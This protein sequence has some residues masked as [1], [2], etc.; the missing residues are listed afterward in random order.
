LA[1]GIAQE[2]LILTFLKGL[3][4]SLEAQNGQLFTKLNFL[5]EVVNNKNDAQSGYVE[6]R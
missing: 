2:K 5:R 1:Q 4:N 3:Q 6:S